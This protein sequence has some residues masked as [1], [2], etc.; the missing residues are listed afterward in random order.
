MLVAV[1]TPKER[2]IDGG[3]EAADATVVLR[4]KL[5]LNL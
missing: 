5:A 4:K 1:V 2:I 3:C